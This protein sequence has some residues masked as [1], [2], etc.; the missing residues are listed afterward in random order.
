M[1]PRGLYYEGW[2]LATTPTRERHK[3]QFLEHVSR[4]LR[5]QSA[6]SSEAAI[7]AVFEVLWGHIDAGEI[8]KVID[9]FPPELRELWPRLARND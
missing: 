7:R 8:A 5:G 4:E 6:I 9:L 1:L 3:S 2:R